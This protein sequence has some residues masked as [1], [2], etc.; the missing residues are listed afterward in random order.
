[1]ACQVGPAG[2]LGLR[3]AIDAEPSPALT[4][5]LLEIKDIAKRKFG[6]SATDI[7]ISYSTI[8]IFFK[9]LEFER[10]N[11]IAWLKDCGD[12]SLQK[13]FEPISNPKPA[14]YLPVYYHPSVAPDLEWLADEKRLTIDSIIELHSKTR[15][16]VF[17]TGFAPGFCYLGNIDKKISTPRLR[18]PRPHVSA[19]TVAIADRQTAVYPCESPGGWRLIGSCPEKLFDPNAKTPNRLAIG[20]TV[21]FEPIDGTRYNK[22]MSQR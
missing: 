12:R 17:S 5:Q 14:V 15:Y 8:T 19:G 7:I 4:Q 16:F 9:A 13:Q 20:D 3:L 1:M 10:D 2:E 21:K 22:I 11:T 6:K 18:T